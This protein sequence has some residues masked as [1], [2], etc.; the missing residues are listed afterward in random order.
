MSDD[1]A[2]NPGRVLVVYYSVSGNTARVARDI[3]KTLGADVESLRDRGHGTGFRHYLK[4]GLDAARGKSAALGETI[5]NPRN[6]DLTVIGT[7]V[8]AWHMTPAIRAYLNRYRTEFRDVA[9]F[10][11]SGDTDAAKIVPSME[12]IV[13]RRAVA[14]TGFSAPQLADDRLYAHRLDDFLKSLSRPAT[15]QDRGGPRPGPDVGLR[16]SGA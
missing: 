7:P 8:W 9:F 4:A 6:Y 3:A 1:A 13:G 14:F 10:V 12:S 2:G 11:T 15:L 16:V 5:F